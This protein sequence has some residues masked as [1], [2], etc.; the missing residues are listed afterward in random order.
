MAQ[1][2]ITAIC[3]L[4]LCAHQDY[5]IE[6][7]EMV[8]DGSNSYGEDWAERVQLGKGSGRLVGP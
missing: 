2:T 5:Q 8:V 3:I 6:R 1:Y 7:K 4:R